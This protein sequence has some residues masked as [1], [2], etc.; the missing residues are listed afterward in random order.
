MFYKRLKEL[1]NEK[2]LSQKELGV[3]LKL[4]PSTIAMYE[5]DQRE[6]DTETIKIIAHFFDVSIDFL[7]GNSDIRNPYTEEKAI[8][9]ELISKINNLSPEGREKAKEYI[10]MLKTLDEVK[11]QNITDIRKNG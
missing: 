3:V 7:L 1:R 10:E 4:S 8:D 6:P 9:R 11:G 2:K 5:T